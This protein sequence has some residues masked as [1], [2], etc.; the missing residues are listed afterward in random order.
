MVIYFYE[1][2]S[3][4]LRGA[5]RM[6]RACFPPQ[7]GFG[8][9]PDGIGNTGFP[10]PMAEGKCFDKEKEFAGL[11]FCSICLESRYI[12]TMKTLYKQPDNQSGKPVRTRRSTRLKSGELFAKTQDLQKPMNSIEEA[13][14]CV[15]YYMRRWK[16]ERFHYAFKSGCGIEKLQ[17]R[18]MGGLSP[19]IIGIEIEPSQGPCKLGGPPFTGPRCNGYRWKT[20]GPRLH[21]RSG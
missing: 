18:G 1:C 4:S 12:Q 8:R 2:L 14:E 10:I 17:D 15:G 3:M 21:R 13:Y 11:G 9:Y 5:G 20:G 7:A 16:I 6:G 19:A